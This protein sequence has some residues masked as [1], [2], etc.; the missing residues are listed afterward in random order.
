MALSGTADRAFDRDGVP[1]ASAQGDLLVSCINARV[2]ERRVPV[3]T[4]QLTT[5]RAA[6]G[7]PRL[8]IAERHFVSTCKIIPSLV[9]G[10]G[11]RVRH[12]QRPWLWR[13]RRTL[14]PKRFGQFLRQ[15][16]ALQCFAVLPSRISWWFAVTQV[17]SELQWLL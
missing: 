2:H 11:L 7:L 4:L 13:V 10:G 12:C 15:C 17:W 5:H 8:W 16:S 9:P 6:S 3:S 1:S 14:T